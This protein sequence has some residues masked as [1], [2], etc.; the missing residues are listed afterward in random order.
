[1][2][3]NFVEGGNLSVR[4]TRDFIYRLLT[5]YK[6]SGEPFGPLFFSEISCR[7]GARTLPTISRRGSSNPDM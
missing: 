2:V 4:P 3:D 1:M 5:V 6:G 7:G